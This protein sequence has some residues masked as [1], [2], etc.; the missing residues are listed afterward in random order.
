MGVGVTVRNSIWPKLYFEK[1]EDPRAISSGRFGLFISIIP[2][3]FLSTKKHQRF[4][5]FIER[6]SKLLKR[7]DCSVKLLTDVPKALIY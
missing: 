5:R 1:E 3:K 6:S 7:F 2:V 4:Y